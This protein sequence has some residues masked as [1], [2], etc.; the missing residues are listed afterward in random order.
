MKVGSR[1]FLITSKRPML[2]ESWLSAHSMFN[3]FGSCDEILF[4]T[5]I[6]GEF[7]F[8]VLF[9]FIESKMLF[10]ITS[11]T[12]ML[13]SFEIRTFN[14]WQY[15][16]FSFVIFWVKEFQRI[17]QILPEIWPFDQTSSNVFYLKV[18]NFHL[19]CKF[20]SLHIV[21][22]CNLKKRTFLKFKSCFLVH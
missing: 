14:S 7:F 5:L 15:S 19:C 20:T 13:A 16:D 6:V 10:V 22:V 17:L 11:S 1:E 9:V 8:N 18:R 3:Y 12:F 4:R 2:L 21:F